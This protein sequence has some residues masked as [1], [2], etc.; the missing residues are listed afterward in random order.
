[1]DLKN[2]FKN[3]LSETSSLVGDGFDEATYLL[4][5]TLA[6]FYDVKNL[7]KDKLLSMANDLIAL[8]PIIEKTGF[9]TKEMNIGV[10]MPPRIVFHFEKIADVNKEDIE[11]ILK[12]NDDKTILKVIVNTLVSTD[13]LQRRFITG[14]FKLSEIDIEIGVP[15][16]VNVKLIS[17]NN[18]GDEK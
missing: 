3:I 8:A 10:S 13:E 4:K 17:N 6:K 2:K 11:A 18:S 15:P 9:R 12:E 7:T 5:D 14:N 1:M 16:Q